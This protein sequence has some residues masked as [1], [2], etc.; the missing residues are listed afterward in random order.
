MAVGQGTAHRLEGLA[1]HHDDVSHRHF[2]EEAEILRQM[3]GDFPA[4]PDDAVL[5]HR[6]NGLK[7]FHGRGGFCGARGGMVNG[8]SAP[9]HGDGRL[10][11]G[12]RV[13]ARQ[14]E[15]LELEVVDILDAPGLISSWAEGAAR[16]QAAFWPGPG[17]WC[18][19]GGR[20]RCGRKFPA[21]DR[22]PAPP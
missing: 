17:G 7:R 10:D 6:G 3:P 11:G 19:D 9:S 18:K 4:A 12:M 14:L 13:V 20:R 16:G 5:T 8:G 22:T 21:S 2:P 1:P 15:I